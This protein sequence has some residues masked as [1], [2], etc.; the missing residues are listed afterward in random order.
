MTFFLIK[1][2]IIFG[3]V[4]FIAIQVMATPRLNITVG[5]YGISIPS[6]LSSLPYALPG[7]LE[8]LDKIADRYHFNISSTVLTGHQTKVVRN[9]EELSQYLYLVPE[10]YHK[11][12]KDGSLFFLLHT[13]CQ[14]LNELCALSKGNLH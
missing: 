13:G 7:F 14:D 5:I 12:P 4:L 3:A 8:G 2:L 11:R 9:C 1:Q 10:F 6:I